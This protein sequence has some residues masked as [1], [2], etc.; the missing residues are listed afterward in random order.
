MAVNYVGRPEGAEATKEAIEGGHRFVDESPR[1]C[2]HAMTLVDALYERAEQLPE[3]DLIRMPGVRCTYEQMVHQVDVIAANLFKL[4]IR[5]GDR[6]TSLLPNSVAGVALWFATMKVGGVHVP[7]NTE[8]R[9][10]ALRNALNTASGTAIVVADLFRERLESDPEFDLL[11]ARLGDP[12]ELSRSAEPMDFPAVSEDGYAQAFFTSGTTGQSK[13]CLFDHRYAVRQAELYVRHLRIQA[14][15][16]LFCPFPL[17]HVDAAVLTV[18]PAIVAGATAALAERFSVRRFW[19]Q[20]RELRATVFAYMGATLTMLWNQPE[21]ALDRDHNLRLGWGCP[22][23][24]FASQFEERFNVRLT[25]IYRMTDCGIPVYSPLSR[26]RRPGSCGQVVEPY[27]LRIADD[28]EIQVAS[29]EDGMMMRE[30]LGDPTATAW[31][32]NNG[33]LRTGDIGRIDDEGWLYFVGR[34]KDVIRR[35]GEN[36]NA[37][38]IEEVV[39]EHPNVA[40]VVAYELR[41]T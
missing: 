24:D 15:D 2:Q 1:R 36:I 4:G 40:L 17:Y 41:A 7:V 8:L 28:G 34:K 35:R 33:W 11:E 3:K 12:E 10:T 18:A 6:V 31:T 30:Y 26:P 38:D 27:S 13:A 22:M 21:S 5:A 25:E 23:P 9:G 20:A 32:L 19:T 37:V 39:A 29:N 16:V 14:D